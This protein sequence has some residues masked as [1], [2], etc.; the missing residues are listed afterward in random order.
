M[1]LLLRYGG[2][3][4]NLTIGFICICAAIG[5]LFSTEQRDR[6]VL[7]WADRH[8]CPWSFVSC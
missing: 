6:E 2:P 3:K 5:A 1:N 8:R 4:V 7:A